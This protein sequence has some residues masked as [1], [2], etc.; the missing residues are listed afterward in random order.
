MTVVY[1]QDFSIKIKSIVDLLQYPKFESRKLIAELAK[2]SYAAVKGLKTDEAC[3]ELSI[4]KEVTSQHLRD[5]INH[6]I[7]ELAHTKI[8]EPN[9]VK[10]RVINEAAGKLKTTLETL[11]AVLSLT[12]EIASEKAA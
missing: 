2:E 11:L 12:M 8:Y 3:P 4:Q 1:Y 9:A 5:I 10:T 6:E 7:K